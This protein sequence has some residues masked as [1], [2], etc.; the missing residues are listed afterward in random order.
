[1]PYPE[2]ICQYLSSTNPPA[3]ASTPT[4]L[5]MPLPQPHHHRP[6]DK[7]TTPSPLLSPPM[8]FHCS[9][10]LPVDSLPKPGLPPLAPSL[11]QGTICQPCPLSYAQA[12]LTAVSHAGDAKHLMFLASI[13]FSMVPVRTI[14]LLI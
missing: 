11:K 13:L 12:D 5:L 2:L 1:M 3:S 14:P 9:K 6:R 4:A 8:S 7:P 10:C